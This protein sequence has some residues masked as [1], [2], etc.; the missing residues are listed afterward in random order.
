MEVDNESNI[1]CGFCFEEEGGVDYEGD[2]VEIVR[3]YRCDYPICHKCL[4]RYFND[5]PAREVG[6]VNDRCMIPW[7]FS[8]LRLITRFPADLMRELHRSR[9]DRLLAREN[10][11]YM[12]DTHNRLTVE[13][14]K[15]EVEDYRK[16]YN[17]RSHI[18]AVNRVSSTGSSIPRSRMPARTGSRGYTLEQSRELRE[19]YQ[20]YREVTAEYD[21]ALKAIQGENVELAG[22]CTYP[23]CTGFLLKSNL[24]CRICSRQQCPD[25]AR[26]MDEEE[27]HVC[28]PDDIKT[29]QLIVSTS[30]RCPNTNCGS[31]ISRSEG[32]ND[33]WCTQCHTAFNYN[34]GQILDPSRTR[35]YENPELRDYL[36]RTN[37]N[38][39]RLRRNFGCFIE[40]DLTETD[41]QYSRPE[42]ELVTALR[43]VIAMQRIL[44]ANEVDPYNIETLAD[45]RMQ[46]AR[47]NRSVTDPSLADRIVEHIA[48]RDRSIEKRRAFNN[49]FDL[50]IK[51]IKDIILG[52][53]R[54][55]DI[56]EE[57]TEEIRDEY[58]ISIHEAHEFMLEAL[59]E[60]KRIYGDYN[61]DNLQ[62]FNDLEA[63]LWNLPNEIPELRH[64]T[65]IAIPQDPFNRN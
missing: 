21:Q 49:L 46:L 52:I 50:F 60:A 45:I 12:Q 47:A 43:S 4:I 48:D 61:R 54:R 56:T 40:G 2:V 24:I 31:W 44:E 36:N 22:R 9:V 26:I 15:E 37:D 23:G 3:C 59:N 34:T 29:H 27:P 30:V 16:E 41:L 11:E 10:S 57:Y 5:Y 53:N 55:I 7:D 63:L 20:E 14:L 6:C 18:A 13:R 32:C 42:I 17:R 8:H 62:Y 51:I 65:D 35:G 38:D 33:M 58:L 28:N 64:A 39:P 19:F 1:E 25:C